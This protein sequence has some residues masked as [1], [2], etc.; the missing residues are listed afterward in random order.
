[1]SISIDY[2]ST[3]LHQL[4][5]SLKLL[6]LASLFIGLLFIHNPNFLFY[7]IIGSLVLYLFSTGH[8]WK[9][10]CLLALPLFIIFIS[11]ATTM[12]FFGDGEHTW[13][14]WGIIHITE[15]SFYRGIHLGLRSC[16]FGLL[17][18]L[19]ALTTRP[20]QLFYSTMQQ[21]KIKPKYAYSFMAAIRMLPIILEEFQSLRRALKVRGVQYTKGI[22]GIYEKIKLYAIPLLAQSIRRAHRIAV[23]MEAKQFSRNEQRTFYYQLSYSVKDILFLALLAGW[24]F[25]SYLGSSSFAIFPVDY[26]R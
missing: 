25:L 4:N 11:S 5:P 19:F 10:L 8:S 26:V 18:L 14:K 22:K 7:V 13:F 17:S 15:E 21:L 1:M 20:V 16:V 24:L 2:R 3:W 9:L 12:I 23:A 6:T